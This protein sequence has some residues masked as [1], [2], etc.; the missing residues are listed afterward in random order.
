M[1]TPRAKSKER[2]ALGGRHDTITAAHEDHAE[3]IQVARIRTDGGTQMRAEIDEAVVREYAALMKEKHVF[4]PIDVY[5]DGKNYWLADGFHRLLA[6]ELY[7]QLQKKPVEKIAC[8]IHSGDRR[9]AILHAA[10]A[11][12][13]HGL[14]RTNADKRRAVQALLRDKEW[15]HWS[16]REIAKACGVSDRFVGKMREVQ[17]STSNESESQVRK[18]ADGRVM[19]TSN[20]GPRREVDPPRKDPQPVRH[21]R[22]AP[23]PEPA[24]PPS[25]AER[26]A[27]IP[28]VARKAARL[29]NVAEVCELLIDHLDDYQDG[30]GDYDGSRE[31]RK[32]MRHM[33]E[34]IQRHLDAY[35]GGSDA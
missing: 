14:R 26:A 12:A 29:H 21:P 13:R 33:Q 11:N 9:D 4:P 22:P 17:D 6:W 23:Q 16:N 5:H 25:P 18:T 35:E 1:M 28:A 31:V 27:R 32:W 30:T 10:G 7:H 24:P 19:D 2:V 15:Q 3:L 20:I 8:H 34:T